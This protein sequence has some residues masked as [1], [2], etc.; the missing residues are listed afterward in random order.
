MYRLF[1]VY[2]HSSRVISTHDMRKV[3]KKKQNILKDEEKVEEQS[4]SISIG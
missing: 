4:Q 3:E 1:I 2:Y